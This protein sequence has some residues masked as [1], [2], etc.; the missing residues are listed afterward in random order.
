MRRHLGLSIA[1]LASLLFVVGVVA[2]GGGGQPT[3]TGD[4]TEPQATHTQ[5]N[6]ASGNGLTTPIASHGEPVRDYV[7]LI[8]NL[9]AAGAMVRPMGEVS[10]PF[11]S[12]TG[13]KITLN[14]GEVQVFEYKDAAAADAD[15][16]QVSP[17]LKVVGN[18]MVEWVGPPHLYKKGRLLALYEGE[19]SAVVTVLES[20]LGPQFAGQ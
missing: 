6:D 8:D 1:S 19:S 16:A 3:P 11:F 10:Q 14:G 5:S 18:T 15:A 7:S 2:C 9:R 4:Q 13:Y 12:V 20:V 17:D